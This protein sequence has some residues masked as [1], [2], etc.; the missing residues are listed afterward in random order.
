MGIKQVIE[1]DFD[2]TRLPEGTEPVDVTY[3]GKTYPVYLSDANKERFVNFLNGTA[4]LSTKTA[5]KA[6]A[7]SG[8]AGKKTETYG[9]NYADVKA[10]AI[11]KKMKGKGG[12]PITEDTKVLHQGIYDDYKTFMDSEDS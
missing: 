8:T 1:D 10:W 7:A 5:P 9:Y 11:S 6:S 4:P 12:N 3:D 2:G